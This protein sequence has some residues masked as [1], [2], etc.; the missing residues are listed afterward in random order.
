MLTF[1]YGTMF[2]GKSAQLIAQVSNRARQGLKVLCFSAH[3]SNTHISSRIAEYSSLSCVK[4]F[5]IANLLRRTTSGSNAPL[6]SAIYIDEAQF[7]TKSQVE[8]LCRL[9]DCLKIPVFCFGLRTDYMGELFEGSQYLL[10]WADRLVE[11]ESWAQDGDSARFTIRTHSETGERMRE[12]SQEAV[13]GDFRA[14]SR[15]EFEL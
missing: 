5:E 6:P 3:P 2:A 15:R 4:W 1:Y 10:A 8:H 7:L 12:G 9:V 11:I 14:V 13:S